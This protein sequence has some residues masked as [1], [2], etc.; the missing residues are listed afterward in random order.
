MD[1]RF[2]ETAEVCEGGGGRL[3]QTLTSEHRSVANLSIDQC[4]S[5]RSK[6]SEV[7]ISC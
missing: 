5:R 1:L 3:A 7:L 4:T 2:L 6:Q